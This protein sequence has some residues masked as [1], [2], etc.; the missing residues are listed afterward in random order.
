MPMATAFKKNSGD[1]VLQLPDE[2]VSPARKR[3]SQIATAAEAAQTYRTVCDLHILFDR[4]N[5][6]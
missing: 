2:V 1:V 4:N 5:F 3:S 6:L